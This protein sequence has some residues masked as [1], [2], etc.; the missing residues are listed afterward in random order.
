MEGKALRRGLS[1]DVSAT[2][3][4]SAQA[5]TLKTRPS[6]IPYPVRNWPREQPVWSN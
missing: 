5:R 2:S 4:S 6:L 3:S 1:Q